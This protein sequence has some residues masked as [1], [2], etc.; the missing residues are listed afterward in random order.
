MSLAKEQDQE[1]Y[2]DAY[3]AETKKRRRSLLG[4]ASLLLLLK[5]A[6]FRINK[7]PVLG[8]EVS[9]DHESMFY[10]VFTLILLYLLISFAFSA[11]PEYSEWNLQKARRKEKFSTNHT[12]SI[13]S[14]NDKNV[15]LYPKMNSFWLNLWVRLKTRLDAWLH[16]LYSHIAPYRVNFEFWLPIVLGIVAIISA[17]FI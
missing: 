7:L 16:R 6:G 17:L 1:L 15:L 4:A 10:L 14:D 3:S 11:I 9:I 12:G 13:L 5:F 8:G 2:F